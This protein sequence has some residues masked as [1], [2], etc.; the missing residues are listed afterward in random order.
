MLRIS[1]G[2]EK[3]A[4][5]AY[6]LLGVRIL[7]L[8]EGR[9][10]I[11]GKTPKPPSDASFLVTGPETALRTFRATLLS[12]GSRRKLKNDGSIEEPGG[13][14]FTFATDFESSGEPSAFDVVS[15]IDHVKHQPTNQLLC[16]FVNAKYVTSLEH[17][18]SGDWDSVKR[19]VER[20]VR[21]AG[22]Y[23]IRESTAASAPVLGEW[24]RAL[25]L[26]DVA[27]PPAQKPEPKTG[28]EY[29]IYFN[30][31]FTATF[32]ADATADTASLKETADRLIRGFKTLTNG[33]ILEVKRVGVSLA[34]LFI[35]DQAAFW[36]TLGDGR[37]QKVVIPMGSSIKE[38][39]YAV[40]APS[41]QTIYYRRIDQAKGSAYTHVEDRALFSVDNG[42]VYPTP[43]KAPKND[44]KAIVAKAREAVKGKSLWA[45]GTILIK[46]NEPGTA[47]TCGVWTKEKAK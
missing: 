34:T 37:S 17:N 6:Y 26:Q 19:H 7:A 12:E 40:G 18:S 13:D 31:V 24:D 2:L 43:F 25:D 22:R 33:D 44:V 9:D 15:K 42:G 1:S 3:T 46:A 21:Q 8:G 4:L 30:G 23:T 39:G 11:L 20:E 5:E 35:G 14:S 38:L 41:G 27:G 28:C 45:D 29:S 47:F 32:K 36:V 16:V 10:W